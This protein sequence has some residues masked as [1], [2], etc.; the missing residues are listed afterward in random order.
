[1]VI[2]KL[3]KIWLN[4]AKFTANKGKCRKLRD[5]VF[6][7]VIAKTKQKTLRVKR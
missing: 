7:G 1:L 4:H 6:V 5:I 2:T 3:S